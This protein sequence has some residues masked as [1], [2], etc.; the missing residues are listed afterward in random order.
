MV[1]GSSFWYQSTTDHRLQYLIQQ[2][3]PS[4]TLP[5]SFLHPPILSWCANTSWAWS[6]LCAA[7]ISSTSLRSIFVCCA[8]SFFSPPSGSEE[9][10]G[11]LQ[12]LLML[13]SLS[14]VSVRRRDA[15]SVRCNSNRHS[16]PRDVFDVQT[17]AGVVIFIQI[18][19]HVTRIPL[20][21]LLVRPMNS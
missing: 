8:C 18:S 4:Q 21:P 13:S 9:W 12:A 20:A 6:L 10:M 7:T 1:Q 15:H 3:P 17:C 19:K 11:D 16:L 2:L 14:G 5:T